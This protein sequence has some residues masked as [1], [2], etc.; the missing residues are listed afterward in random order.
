MPFVSIKYVA[1]NLARD[2]EG[3]KNR[4]A[5]RVATALSEEMG[6]SKGDVWVTFE[7]VPAADFYVGPDSVAAIRARKT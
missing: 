3:K 4:I 5:D 6:L 7:G 2:G 1:E